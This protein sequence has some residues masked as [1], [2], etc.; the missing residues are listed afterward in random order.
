MRP[1][2]D[3]LLPAIRWTFEHRVVPSL[4]DP[5]AQSY[6]RTISVLLEQVQARL[7]YEGATLDADNRDLRALL[8]SLRESVD[9]PLREEIESALERPGHDEAEYRDVRA[10]VDEAAR[11]RSVLNRAI[12]QLPSPRRTEI[13][14]YLAR[15]VERGARC[16]P[17]SQRMSAF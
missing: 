17:T 14:A 2:V 11:L 13:R 6:A 3:E 15:Q 1:R 8:D 4:D 12:R 5:L 16:V 10:L 9:S 7:R